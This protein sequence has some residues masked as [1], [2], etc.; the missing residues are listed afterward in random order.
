VYTV[1]KGVYIG[2]VLIDTSVLLPFQ[3]IGT[4]CHKCGRIKAKV[5][6]PQKVKQ[7]PNAFDAVAECY[8]FLAIANANAEAIDLQFIISPCWEGCTLCPYLFQ[9]Y[10]TL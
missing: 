4:S 7:Y 2:I 9:A 5:L 8:S 6:T 3:L 1:Y 10:L